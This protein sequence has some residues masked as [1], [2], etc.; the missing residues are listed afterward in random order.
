M[1]PT[2]GAGSQGGESSHIL[3]VSEMP[4]HNHRQ[5]VTAPTSS[6]AG[7]RVDY[8]SDASSVAYDQG[9]TTGSAGGGQAHNNM[10]PYLAVYIWKRTA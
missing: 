4:V 7:V 10:P 3:S 6:G 8:S 2:Y 5:Y 9:I 1:S